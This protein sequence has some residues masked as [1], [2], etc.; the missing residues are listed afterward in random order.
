MECAQVRVTGG[1]GV[2]SP[3]TVPIPGV[4]KVRR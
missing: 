4:Y 2:E 3:A 1:T